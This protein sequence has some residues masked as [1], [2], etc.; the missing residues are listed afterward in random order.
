[1]SYLSLFFCRAILDQKIMNIRKV[2]DLI[3]LSSVKDLK[4]VP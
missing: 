4:R 2:L 3:C 1:M